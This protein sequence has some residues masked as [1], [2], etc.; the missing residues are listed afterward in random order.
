[1]RLFAWAR[2][3]SG[4]QL[5]RT[6]RSGPHRVTLLGV[7]HLSAGEMAK[8]EGSTKLWQVAQALLAVEAAVISREY[9]LNGVQLDVGIPLLN[10]P[11]RGTAGPLCS[12]LLGSR[13]MA[14]ST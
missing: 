9:L 3:P 1:M 5:V 11:G 8:T 10:G 4:E 2:A 13:A 7:S 6:V 12:Q 14:D